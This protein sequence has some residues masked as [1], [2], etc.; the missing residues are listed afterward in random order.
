MSTDEHFNAHGVIPPVLDDHQPTDMPAANTIAIATVTLL[1]VGLL[2]ITI[3]HGRNAFEAGA[4]H[5]VP[6][7]D[8]RIAR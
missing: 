3:I 8:V 2:E 7:E 6:M 5:P 1:G 4:S